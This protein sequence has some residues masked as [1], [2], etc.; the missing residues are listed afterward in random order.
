MPDL[1]QIV[2]GTTG[3]TRER[4]PRPSS[5]ATTPLQARK[6]PAFEAPELPKLRA[7]SV[8]CCPLLL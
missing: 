8:L 5:A 6:V 4:S 2:R 7:L 1:C 3:N